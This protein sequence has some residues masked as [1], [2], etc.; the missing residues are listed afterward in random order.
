V[1]KPAARILKIFAALLLVALGVGFAIQAQKYFSDRGRKE[2]ARKQIAAGDAFDTSAPI[3]AEVLQA[4]NWQNFQELTQKIGTDAAKI[5]QVLRLTSGLQNSAAVY[6]RGFVLMID[7]KPAQSLYEFDRLTTDE[8]PA[9]FLYPPYRLQRQMRPLEPNRY[10]A[11]LRK[12]IAAGEVSSL[13]KARVQAQEGDPYS[14]IS[15]Y[16][17]TDPAQ[18]VQYDIACL[19]KIGMQSGLY[20]EVRRMIAGALNSK[21]VSSKIEAELRQLAVLEPSESELRLLKR[22]LKEELIQDSGASKIAASSLAQVLETRK[23]FLQ[24][25]YQTILQQYQNANPIALPTETV[26]LLFL[27]AVEVRNSLEVDRWGQEIKRRHPTQEVIDWVT[28][29]KTSAK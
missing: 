2:K 11:P 7:N 20:S 13:I 8:I 15:S 5:R 18:W 19:K 9:A 1:E 16:M 17:Q 29:L 28:E 10:L 14:A 24:R 6:L 3:S 25:D 27:S 22:K 12:A 4:L 26:L 23:L 21:R